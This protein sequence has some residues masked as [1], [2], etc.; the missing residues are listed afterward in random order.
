M[1][2]KCKKGSEQCY[3]LKEMTLLFE[4]GQRLITSKELKNDLSPILKMLVEYLDAERSFLTIYNRNNS[5]IGIEAAYGLSHQQ[6]SR[7]KY[8]LGEGVIGKVVELGQPIV[9]QE[10][11][12]SNLF[13]NKTRSEV[14]KAGRE[15]TF[16]CVPIM[17]LNKTS[18]ALSVV[19]PF[20]PHITYE[21]DIHLL[22][23]IGSLIAKTVETRQ[24]KLEELEELK[25]KNKEL[26][27]EIDRGN[28][29][30]NMVGNSTKMQ[31]VFSLVEMVAKTNSTVMI[32]GESGIGKE[33]VAEAIH[34]RSERANKKMV[35]VNCSALPD[36]LIESELFGH[37][38]GAFTGADQRRVGRFELAD[39]GTIFLDEIGDLPLQ[40]QVKLLRILQER[41]FERLGGSETIKVDVRIVCATNKHLEQ[42]IEDGLF[43]EDFFY[44]INVF[45]IFVPALRERRNDI[46][47]LADH[48]ISK[49]NNKNRANITRIT[50][51]A[52]NM[53]MVY[54]WPGNVR[55]LENVIERACILSKDNVVHSYNLPP[56][57][58]TAD[59]TATGSQD[60][61]Q[62]VLERLEKQLILEGL[63]STKGNISK[64]AE[65]LKITERKL[66]TRIKKYNIDAWRYKV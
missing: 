10:I 59:S 16:I 23:I 65:I 36:S 64:A 17:V 51:S 4:I 28:F 58:Q 2:T 20:N 3:G 47:L 31:D 6:Q 60:G 27:S 15:L 5:N 53:L 30:S 43:R 33:L 13:L 57:L 32:R 40:T 8:R 42:S 50:T 45:P 11:S 12:K 52:I 46:P 49:F 62:G 54:G 55:E 35:K 61:M 29:S 41:E 1:H 26:Q 18:G 39:G 24:V 66:G 9:I 14:R 44:R 37:E 7:G 48:F 56:T 21:E 38:K 19:R 34:N 25:Q 22:S 63:T